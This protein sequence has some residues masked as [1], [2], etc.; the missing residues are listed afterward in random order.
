MKKERILH[1][2][3]KIW[4]GAKLPHRKDTAELESEIFPSPSTVTIP[5]SQHI[6]APC[7]PT[8]AVGDNVFVGTKIA[9]SEAFVSAPIHSSVSGTVKEIKK[10]KVASGSL[11]NAIVIENDHKDQI[12]PNIKPCPVNTPEELI[13]AARNCG[14][15]GL[16]GAGF[17][18]HV[19]LKPDGNRPIDVLI[20]NGAECEPYITADYRAALEDS[21]DIL[22]GI[23]LIKKIL[24]LKKVIIAVE[25]NKPKALKVLFDIAAGKQDVLD[26]VKLMKLKSHYPQGAE[27]VIIYTTTG[28]KVP[29]GKL[30]ADVGCIVMNIT[31]IATLSK[32]I[33]T[34]IPLIKKRV[35]V[36]GNAV[37]NP[38]NL[39]VPIGTAVSEI[40]DYCE[41]ENPEKILM[42]GPMMGVAVTDTAIPIV[43][44][45]N[46]VLCFNGKEA[47]GFD[48]TNCINC[49]RCIMACPMNLHPREVELS[50][51]FN[52]GAEKYKK[53]NADYCIECGSCA[54]SCPARRPLV[55]TM[56]LAKQ[57]IRKAGA[58]N[59]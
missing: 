5:V 39:I 14:L 26:E 57:E 52:E 29:L 48:P 59:A 34:G 42:G 55:E 41:A 12:D 58:K 1:P 27:K 46:A 19:K 13:A 47:N 3:A 38:K 18:A 40:L 7:E 35:T 10:V 25:D 37:K 44:A 51:D 16:G 21:E 53:L 24:G 32:Y 50:V 36:A 23:Y 33:K 30:P 4:G 8:V 22:D 56:R 2:A 9:D 28:R 17:P 49:G 45:N 11:C 43:K 6:G 54:F 15:V 20:V 31:S